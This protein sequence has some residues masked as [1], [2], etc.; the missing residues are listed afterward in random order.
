MK[1]TDYKNFKH[2][3]SLEHLRDVLLAEYQKQKDIRD[4]KIEGVSVQ[5]RYNSEYREGVNWWA[6]PIYN[7]KVEDKDYSKY[8]PET[9]RAVMAVPGVINCAI[10]YIAPDSFIPDHTDDYYDM[11]EAVVG[12]MRGVGS[13]IG[14]DMPSSDPEIVG[15][16]ID[17]EIK[18]WGNGDIVSF[19]G[20]KSHG[21]W[22]RSK[23]KW[24]ITMIID[25]EEHLWNL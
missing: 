14:I 6:Y 20:Y 18:G 9:I 25:T 11:S 24:R 7:A 10:N 15:F 1:W 16:H 13:M 22:N 23:D 3:E 12:K 2:H 5:E 19:D 8:W 17:G 4:C 21:G